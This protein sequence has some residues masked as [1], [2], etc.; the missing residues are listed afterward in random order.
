MA[1]KSIDLS[2]YHKCWAKLVEGDNAISYL[3]PTQA[4]CT[5]GNAVLAFQKF[6]GRNAGIA[7][8][9]ITDTLNI[10]I[11][12]PENCLYITNCERTAGFSTYIILIEEDYSKEYFEQVKKAWTY[13]SNWELSQV[14][15]KTLKCLNEDFGV[16]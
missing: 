1:Q 7:K 15:P 6:L 8:Y 3:T 4:E 2:S 16:D 10:Q 11:N 9:E 12:C 13:T 5:N 14:D